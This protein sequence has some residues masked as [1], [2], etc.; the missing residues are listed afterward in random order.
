M[1]IF[2]F[3]AG[4]TWLVSR[5]AENP[6]AI[7]TP[8][9]PWIIDFAT[10]LILFAIVKIST[11]FAFKIQYVLLAIVIASLISMFGGLA[12]IDIVSNWESI[13]WLGDFDGGNSSF[14]IVFAVFFPAVTGIMAGANI[15]GELKNP[16]KAIPSGTLYGVI[17]TTIIYLALIFLAA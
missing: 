15:S 17:L 4:V 14:W 2:A 8:V 1:Y 6:D 5:V 7:L 16:R 3:R 12:K 11:E 10:F 9:F 13:E